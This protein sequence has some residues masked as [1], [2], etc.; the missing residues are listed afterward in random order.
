MPIMKLTQILERAARTN[1]NGPAITY[2]GQTQTWQ[3]FSDRTKQLGGALRALGITTDDRVAALSQ[4]SSRLM[5]VFYGPFYAD[6]VL[7][8][9][10]YRWAVPEMITLT[11]RVPSKT[12][13]PFA[14]TSF[15]LVMA[16]R[17]MTS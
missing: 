3:R 5:E 13:A 8:P 2:Q 7:V 6:A 4:N 17:L 16:T 1:P 9:L 12:P 15:L 14:T 10:N 11:T